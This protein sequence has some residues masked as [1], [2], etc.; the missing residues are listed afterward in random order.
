MRISKH[1]LLFI[2]ALI[3]DFI[4]LLYT[5]SSFSI[6]YG[7]ALNYFQGDI[8]STATHNFFDLNHLN[9][10]Y[11]LTHTST[12]IFGQNDIALRLPF[13]LFYISSVIISYLLTKDYFK[14]ENIRLFSIVIFMLLPGI[15]SAALLVNESIIVVFFTLLY[16]YLFKITNK[17]H[18]WLLVLC[19]FIDNSFAIM[20]LALFFY[21]LKKKD[22][23]LLIVSLI[24]F[25][26]SMQ[27]YGFDTGGR[28]KGYFL[29]TFGAYASIFSPMIFLYFFYAMYR[30]MIKWEKDLYWYI[31][32]VAFAFS[33][34]LSM[35]QKINI[36][37][38]AP[39]VVIAIPL[40]V[41]LFMHSFNVR[42]PIF[43]KKHYIFAIF[44]LT[45]LLINFIVFIFN[46][47]LYL[48]LDNPNQHFAANYHI[49]QEL[50][51]K[52]KQN[53]IK[54]ILSDSYEMQTRLKFYGIQK[55]DNLY[56]TETKTQ[57]T[58]H[59][60]IKINGKTI[61]DYYILSLRPA[62]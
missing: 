3:I 50:A 59:I 57:K 7:E 14:S 9:L 2:I 23:I 46:K 13:I 47:Q 8:W 18:Y 45:I 39:F 56:L 12:Y 54:N 61:K 51:E 1:N 55:S 32:F 53:G 30:M 29:D 21:S 31:S 4:I 60:A 28:P 33:L 37:D 43:R 58:K 16:L 17:E 22:N 44:S 49:A 36:E 11:I 25:G 38:F 41:K 27:M 5:A 20:Y 10:L 52:L 6:S 24:L 35:R 62:N 34:I 48:I 19:L 26:I 40:M 42:L 15:N